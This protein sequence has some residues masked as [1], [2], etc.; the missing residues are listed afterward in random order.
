MVLRATAM[1]GLSLLLSGGC[2]GGDSKGTDSGSASADDTGAGGGGGGDSWRPE[3]EGSAYFADGAADNSLFH[4]EMTRCIEPR[5]GEAYYGFVS[6]GGA[7]PIALGAITCA[8][9]EVAFD[10]DIGVNAVIEGY[11][12]FEAW[13]NATGVQG[14]GDALWTGQ[15]DSVV[16]GV[17]RSLLIESTATPSGEG[18]LRA[19]E[20][21]VQAL[22]DHAQE[23]L[24]SGE[25]LA[26]KQADAEAIYYSITGEDPQQAWG[27]DLPIL[28]DDGYVELI[29]S[30]L[31]TASAQVAPGDPI[32]D[33]ANNA[34]DGTQAIGTHADAAAAAALYAS[35]AASEDGANAKIEEAITELGY[36]LDG[37]DA[38]GDGAVDPLTEGAAEAA[39]L[40]VSRMAQ[41]DVESQ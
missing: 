36:A 30:D 15:V 20:S 26:Q 35:A 32:K 12:T 33:Y 18:S 40:F 27:D 28:G 21:S 17:I 6:K 31:E 2:A 11:D 7:D 22:R 13:A 39:I 23:I 10:G 37:E 25:A 38:D 9:E 29:L 24:D 3:G 8:D 34:Y 19:V 5:E 14:E 41:M 16:Y 1:L 4:L